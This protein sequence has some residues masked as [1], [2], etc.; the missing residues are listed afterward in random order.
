MSNNENYKSMKKWNIYLHS[1]C[2]LLVFTAFNTSG[3]ISQ[4]A[5]TG[6]QDETAGTDHEFKG[7]DG[8]ISTSI[9]YT[10]FALSNWIAPIIVEFTSTKFSMMIG[11]SIYALYVATYIYPNALVMWIS[12]ALLGCG[13]GVLWTAQGTFI[14]DNSDEKTMQKN[15]GIFWMF[16]QSG[17][18]WGNLYIYRTLEGKTSIDSES[19]VPLYWTF[20]FLASVGTMLM[21]LLKQYNHID[22]QDYK[23]GYVLDEEQ[24][25]EVE[26]MKNLNCESSSDNEKISEN[27]EDAMTKCKRVFLEAIDL[28]GTKPMLILC[29]HFI[30]TGVIQS[31]WTTVY[32]AMIGG[33]KDFG[34]DSD[35]LT[36]INGITM[37]AGQVVGGLIFSIFPKFMGNR[38]S[39]ENIVI[40]GGV[41]HLVCFAFIYGNF[42]P[43]SPLSDNYIKKS[44]VGLTRGQPGFAEQ[45]PEYFSI[46]NYQISLIIAF[47]LG[48]GDCCFNTQ[49]YS[50]L[51]SM[52][53]NNS[54]PAFAIF[55]SIQ[56]IATAISLSYAGKWILPTQLVIL[57]VFN[58][59]AMVSFY[60]LNKDLQRQT[61]KN[62]HEDK[63]S[64]SYD[65]STTQ[66]TSGLEKSRNVAAVQG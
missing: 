30:Y 59:I 21:I 4:R 50:Y 52:Y 41:I 58:I 33:T 56:S 20:T 43:C 29:L 60:K 14:T 65:E 31:F 55:K 34:A 24:S 32:P 49:T 63:Q 15:T 54:A 45:Y 44:N 12:S 61:N 47:F 18:I 53:K 26:Q 3:G 11:A 1:I 57:C 39:K 23:R 62:D 46:S 48:F 9:V 16:L 35:R 6:Y 37:G 8:F 19:R 5:L 38:L 10:F 25:S 2:F 13:A 66:S 36:G 7:I 42:E 51:G 28:F 17:M 40:M 22:K 27:D 64:S